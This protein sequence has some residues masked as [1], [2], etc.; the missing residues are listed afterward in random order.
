M[1]DNYFNITEELV[2]VGKKINFT[3]LDELISELD[4][5]RHIFLAGMGRSKLMISSFAN[6]LLHLNYS[7]SIV[8]EVTSPHSQ[9]NDLLI[10]CSASGETSNLISIVNTAS[11][12]GVKIFLITANKNSTLSQKANQN[13][14]IP[15]SSKQNFDNITKQPMGTL[16]EQTC[17][18]LF[19]SIILKI[20]KEKQIEESYLYDRHA[21][22]E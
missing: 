11:A 19:D 1:E 9:K 22:F 3:E 15:T 8:G 20:M 16:F 14:I 12:N 5:A 13:F 17:L 6:R 18:V 4:Q 2:A 21:D 7:V 10:I